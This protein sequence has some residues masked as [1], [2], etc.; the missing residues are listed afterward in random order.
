MII[1][2][3]QIMDDGVDEPELCHVC[4]LPP[5]HCLCHEEAATEAAME[6]CPH[7]GSGMELRPDGYMCVHVACCYFG[8]NPK[9]NDQADQRRPAQ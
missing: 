2:D 5:I 4:D 3:G 6:T 1:I 8:S 7:C 9:P